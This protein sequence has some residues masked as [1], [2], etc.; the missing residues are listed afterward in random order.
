MLIYSAHMLLS[1]DMEIDL[2]YDGHFLK[3][4]RPET[5]DVWKS[6][7]VIVTNVERINLSV[8]KIGGQHLEK[9]NNR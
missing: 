2:T 8:P 3:W 4:H 6:S 7:V 1:R 9:T 5:F